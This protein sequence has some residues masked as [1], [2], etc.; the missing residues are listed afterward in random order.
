MF[1]RAKNQLTVEFLDETIHLETQIASFLAD[2]KAQE[3]T[4]NTIE[5]CRKML[6]SLRPAPHPQPRGRSLRTTLCW[7]CTWHR[8]GWP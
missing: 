3:L 6:F 7:R 8:S 1:S 4:P 2:G 5:Y